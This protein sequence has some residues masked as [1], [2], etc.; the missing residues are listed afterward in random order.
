MCLVID[1]I[2]R[3][4]SL[5]VE[6]GETE[7]KEEM[8]GRDSWDRQED[9]SKDHKKMEEGV[10]LFKTSISCHTIDLDSSIH[11]RGRLTQADIS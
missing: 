2:S 11:L 6:E 4:D 3:D 9:N 8:K 7:R 5:S 10:T 1:I